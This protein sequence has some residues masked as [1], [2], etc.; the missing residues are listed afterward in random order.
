MSQ[1]LKLICSHH[2]TKFTTISVIVRFR[3]HTFPLRLNAESV[4]F[5]QLFGQHLINTIGFNEALRGLEGTGWSIKTGWK[6]KFNSSRFCKRI[7]KSEV[8]LESWETKLFPHYFLNTEFSKW[9]SPNWRQLRVRF[10]I[11][12]VT[13]FVTLMVT[14]WGLSQ[15]PLSFT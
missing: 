5:K 3:E 13:S 9:I 7:F 12:S 1:F 6:T 2:R 11:L 8:A 14:V 15:Q 4:N 10:F